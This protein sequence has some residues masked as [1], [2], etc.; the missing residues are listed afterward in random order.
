MSHPVYPNSEAQAKKTEADW[1]TLTWLAGQPVGNVEKAVFG[2]V[3]IK[4]GQCN[5]RHAHFKCE[6][7]LYL[8]SGKLRHTLG[9]E[10]FEM[11][12]GDTIVIPRGVFHNAISIGDEDADMMI[13][14]NETERDFVLEEDAK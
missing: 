2:R 1:G 11:N 4:P 13:V 9:D 14:F 5:P 7:V 3:T 12:P 8:L 10:A 6:E